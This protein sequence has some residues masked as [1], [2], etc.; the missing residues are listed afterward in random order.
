MPHFD[1][2]VVDDTKTGGGFQPLPPGEYTVKIAEIQV[3]RT[4]KGDP[5]WACKYEVDVDGKDHWIWDN[6][7]WSQA[8]AVRV[9]QFLKGFMV[10]KDDKQD[11]EPADLLLPMPS[12]G[13]IRVEIEKDQNGRDR[14]VVP[15][16]GYH[17]Y[18]DKPKDDIGF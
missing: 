8:A 15:F 1:G 11:Y 3:R 17:T 14:N 7:V 13:V 6:I 5:Y 12:V 4:K 2:K 18:S 10:Y 9:K 16:D